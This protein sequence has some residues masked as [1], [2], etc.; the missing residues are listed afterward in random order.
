MAKNKRERIAQETERFL[1]KHEDVVMPYMFML[2]AAI[3]AIIGAVSV[4][5]EVLKDI[6]KWLLNSLLYSPV[7]FFIAVA[8]VALISMPHITKKLD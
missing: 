2:T 1:D 6:P 3:S 4:D 5:G 7:G 8:V